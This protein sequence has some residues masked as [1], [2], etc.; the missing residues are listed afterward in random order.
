[1]NRLLYP[2]IRIMED[3]IDTFWCFFHQ[4]K[5]YSELLGPERPGIIKHLV[6]LTKLLEV[7]LSCCLIQETDFHFQVVDPA[8]HRYL[9]SVRGTHIFFC[10]RWFFYLFAKDFSNNDVRAFFFVS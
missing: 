10:Y 1:M 3:E 8:V 6:S 4:T 2:M 7:V 5:K 9:M